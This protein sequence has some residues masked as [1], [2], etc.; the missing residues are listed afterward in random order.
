MNERVHGCRGGHYDMQRQRQANAAAES[1]GDPLPHPYL[2]QLAPRS[3]ALYGVDYFHAE[4]ERRSQRAALAAAAATTSQARTGT[5][6]APQAT[7]LLALAAPPANPPPANLPPADAPPANPP[8]ASSPPQPLA[9][10]L[11]SSQQ[12]RIEA[13]RLAALA[14]RGPVLLTHLAWQAQVRS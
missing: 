9:T 6:A 8:P 10:V 12:K 4:L 1:R 11:S 13:S 2:P 14:R 5:L 3:Q 7:G